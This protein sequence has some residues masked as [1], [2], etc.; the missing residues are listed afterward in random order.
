MTP[1]YL[2]TYATKLGSTTEVAHEIRETISQ[3]G[4]TV[5]ILPIKDVKDV[6]SYDKIII[7]SAIRMGN[8][9][10]EAVNFVKSHQAALQKIPAAIFTVHILSQ[11][12][13]PESLKERSAYTA[14][15][16]EMVTPTSEAFFAGKID[17]DK[18]GFLERLLF[19]AIKPP[20]GD[21]R[22][23]EE[24]RNWANQRV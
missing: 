20:D 15:V 22:N 17:P 6:S 4:V 13:D 5:D 12:D 3:K 14:Q 19:K 11:G 10:P 21:F 9:L 8:W 1:K 24:I 2:V 16:R 7:G 18:L 23:W